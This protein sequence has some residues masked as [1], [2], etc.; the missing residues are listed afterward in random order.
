[1]YWI[2]S[3]FFSKYSYYHSCLIS[4]TL[5]NIGV[6]LL[7][8]VKYIF[9]TFWPNLPL[10]KL[11]CVEEGMTDPPIPIWPY[12]VAMPIYIGL[13]T[14]RQI[15]YLPS[16]VIHIYIYIYIYKVNWSYEQLA[17][18]LASRLKKSMVNKRLGNIKLWIVMHIFKKEKYNCQ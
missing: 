8:L 14:R 7:G 9:I 15:P 4:F 6:I 3:G 5:I 10:A 11:I 16:F 12:S 17:I 18:A 13:N 1:M 2:L